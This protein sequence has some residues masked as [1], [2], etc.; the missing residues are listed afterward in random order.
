[1][2]SIFLIESLGSLVDFFAEIICWDGVIG[3][4]LRLFAGCDKTN[5]ICISKFNNGINFVGEPFVPGEDILG[6]YPDA[7]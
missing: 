3:D 2:F 1:M 7:R 4:R 6:Q 5:P